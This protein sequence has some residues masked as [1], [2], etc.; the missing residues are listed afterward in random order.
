MSEH[1][2]SITRI[3]GTAMQDTGEFVIYHMMTMLPGDG[4]FLVIRGRPD[5]IE[6][7][8]QSL[9]AQLFPYGDIQQGDD[10]K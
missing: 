10:I 3:R 2:I 8:Q 4:D 6:S 1:T 9:A 7:V 5:L